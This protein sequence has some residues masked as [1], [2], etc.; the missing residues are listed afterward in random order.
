MGADLGE[1]R[2]PLPDHY[3]RD[4]GAKILDLTDKVVA[5]SKGEVR[6]T[7][8]QTVAHHHIGESDAGCQDLHPRLAGTWLRHLTLHDLEY[9]RPTLPRKKHLLLFHPRVLSV[10]Q[11]CS[12]L[13]G[14]AYVRPCSASASATQARA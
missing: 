6:H 8:V 10:S 14:S 2:D 1:R 7:R 4:V 3:P 12:Y 5:G 9:L 11:F 13:N